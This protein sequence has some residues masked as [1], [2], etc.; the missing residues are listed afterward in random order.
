SARWALSIPPATAAAFSN[1]TCSQGTFQAVVGKRVV[2]TSRQPVAF[3]TKV[4]FAIVSRTVRTTTGIPHPWQ[5]EWPP[6]RGGTPCSFCPSCFRR[7]IAHHARPHMPFHDRRRSGGCPRDGDR[8]RRAR[9]RGP[10]AATRSRR[11]QR[12]ARREAAGCPRVSP[13]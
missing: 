12:R 10:E 8:G 6:R 4:G 2:A 1:A 5:S 3:T 11:A 7:D 13:R 9:R